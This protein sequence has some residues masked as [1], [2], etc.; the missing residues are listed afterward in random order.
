M[1]PSAEEFARWRDDRVTRWVFK[2]LTT[3]MAE[4]RDA[5]LSASWGNGTADP[6]LLTELRTRADANETLMATSYEGF[7]ETNGDEPNNDQG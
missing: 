4:C 6:M 5:W 1:A 7:C 3:N 2:A